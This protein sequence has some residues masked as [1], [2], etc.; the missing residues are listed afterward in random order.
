MVKL[1]KGGYNII[2]KDT[3]QVAKEPGLSKVCS[4]LNA[5]KPKHLLTSYFTILSSPYSIDGD[6]WYSPPGVEA[7]ALSSCASSIS[8]S[9]DSVPLRFRLFDT[10]LLR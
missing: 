10:W 8:L 7:I 6:E 3:S 9:F 5:T 1:S 2:K 4:S